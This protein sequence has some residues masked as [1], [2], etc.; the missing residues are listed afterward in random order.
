MVF[1]IQKETVILEIIKEI[2][3]YESVDKNLLQRIKIE[4]ARRLRASFIPRDH[5]IISKLDQNLRKK[6]KA[7]SKPVRSIS[8]IIVVSV[9]TKPAPCPGSCIYC[10]GGLTLSAI[11]SPK[12]Y[13]GHEPA[14]RR[15][16]ELN[17][18]PYLQVVRR[19]HHLERLGHPSDKVSVIIM[20]GTFVALSKDYRDE[21]MRGVYEGILGC[22]Y[23]HLSLEELKTAL[24][25]APKRLVELTFETRP[26]FCFENHVDEFLRYGATRIEIGV[27]CLSD[28]VLEFIRRGHD[29]EHVRR[30]FRIA[31]DAGFK[32]VAHMMPNL[33]PNPSPERDFRDFIKLIEDPDFRPDMIKI[34][35]T[36]VV[37]GTELYNM[38]MR[39]EYRP[40]PEEDLIKLIARVKKLLP[41]WI[42]V[43]RVQRDIPTYLIETGCSFG[44]LRE[45]VRRHM[46]KLGWRCRCIRCREVGHRILKEGYSLDLSRIRLVRRRY[47]ASEGIEI[48]LS[49]EDVR[50]DTIFGMLRLRI[51]SEFSHRPE[52]SHNTAIVRELHVYGSLVPLRERKPESAQHRGLGA[53][54]LRE[55]ELTAMEDYDAEK[56]AILSG[57]GVREYYRRFGYKLEGPYMVK[58][59]R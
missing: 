13:S 15:A 54:L 8:G 23:P 33:P 11:P 27:Q 59:L 57:I 9:F 4:V 2:Q 18:D 43:Q 28:D 39:G 42:R 36:V 51:P 21:F 58:K 17:Y 56:I 22:R 55:A 12:S 44:N 7:S 6:I 35:P 19:I 16:A 41:P 3:K 30:A 48:F 32:I 45:I 25:A 49:Y 26:D 14:A 53:S 40:Y 29:V 1:M 46:E 31:K 10:P 5:E 34:Y 20:G 52:I 37:K 47:K 38:W 24:E 50:S